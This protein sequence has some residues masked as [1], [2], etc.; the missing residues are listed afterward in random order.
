M[1]RRCYRVYIERVAASRTWPVLPEKTRKTRHAV[2]FR[3]DE[4]TAMSLPVLASGTTMPGS[5]SNPRKQGN[6]GIPRPLAANRN[7]RCRGAERRKH[8]QAMGHR[9]G[10]P[11]DSPF[12]YTLTY[13]L[14]DNERSLAHK[15]Q[16]SRLCSCIISGT[17]LALY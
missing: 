5:N 9:F 7:L 17:A 15:F 13:L 12:G 11:G 10:S 2:A 3:A 6:L 14:A 8:R 4:N 16:H 1:T